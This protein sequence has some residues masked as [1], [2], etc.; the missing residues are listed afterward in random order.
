MSIVYGWAAQGWILYDGCWVF[1]NLSTDGRPSLFV[2]EN[3]FGHQS[4]FHLELGLGLKPRVWFN[5]D[6]HRGLYS[7]NLANATGHSLRKADSYP[8]TCT[9]FKQMPPWHTQITASSKSQEMLL[10]TQWYWGLRNECVGQKCQ[11]LKVW[12]M[13]A[14]RKHGLYKWT[15]DIR[16]SSRTRKHECDHLLYSSAEDSVKFLKRLPET[17]KLSGF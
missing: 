4:Q 16:K 5:L 7:L 8:R 12:G 11:I 14:K 9:S 6:P 10:V 3:P 17:E 2:T 13:D 15:P 1:V